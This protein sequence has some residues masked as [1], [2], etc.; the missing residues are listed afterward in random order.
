MRDRLSCWWRSTVGRKALAA[1]SGLALAV[2]V[3]L[4]LAGNL[5]LFAGPGAADGYAAALRRAPALLWATRAGLLL[6]AVTHLG[7]V[8][9]L[10]RANWAA[11][12]RRQGQ[13]PDRRPERRLAGLAARG[14]R[15]GGVLLLAF[16]GYHLLHLTLGTLH[17]AFQ[18][19]HP[20]ANVTTG[21]RSPVVAM[22]Y[23]A[24][25]GLLGLHLFHGV[26]AAVRSLGLR[27]AR[28]AERRRPVIGVLA[29]A[30]AVGFASLPLAVLAGWLR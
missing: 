25:A 22:V 3:G 12:P 10:A 30:L 18:P 15:C 26:W 20:Y 11:R 2:W 29:A 5:T 17:P 6:A 1:V 13:V 14:M 8:T 19:G 28:A 4:H 9:S 23:L 21:L 7:A 16:V 27:P 24:A